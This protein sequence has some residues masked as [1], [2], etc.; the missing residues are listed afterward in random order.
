MHSN[1]HAAADFKYWFNL[2]DAVITLDCTKSIDSIGLAIFHNR[3]HFL[4]WRILLFFVHKYT[5]TAA[6]HNGWTLSTDLK[7]FRRAFLSKIVMISR[8]L[9]E[10]KWPK[11]SRITRETHWK[12]RLLCQF[13]YPCRLIVF[14][15][16]SHSSRSSWSVPNE[17]PPARA[18]RTCISLLFPL[19]PLRLQAVSAAFCATRVKKANICSYPKHFRQSGKIAL[20]KWNK[21]ER[22]RKIVGN[23]ENTNNINAIHSRSG[24]EHAAK[25]VYLFVLSLYLSTPRWCSKTIFI[26]WQ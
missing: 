19:F 13:F 23:N 12:N 3:H 16:E 2:F 20:H 21:R 5:S 24:D 25:Y 26:F 18:C 4:H 8:H 9:A 15:I 17:P 14:L 10:Q 7:H 6:G 11:S 22:E 1:P